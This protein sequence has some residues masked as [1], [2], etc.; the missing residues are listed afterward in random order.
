MFGLE[1]MH[2]QHNFL[3]KSVSSAAPPGTF[4]CETTDGL[5]IP[6]SW[7]AVIIADTGVSN[8]RNFSRRSARSATEIRNEFNDYFI[9][10][11]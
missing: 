5:H 10:D 9:T 6:G 8:L 2:Y 7:R 4:N 1:N 3:R 11:E